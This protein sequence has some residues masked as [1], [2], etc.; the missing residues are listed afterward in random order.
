MSTTEAGID[1]AAQPQDLGNIDMKIEVVTIPVSDV[2]R[3]KAFYQGLGWR[4]DADFSPGGPL[5]VVQMTPLHSGASI[6]FS[7][8]L[9]TAFGVPEM[10]PGSQHRLELIVSD[11]E[12]A[13]EDLISRGADVGELFHLGAAGPEPGPDPQRASYGTYAVFSDPDG[14]TWLLQEV[15][16]R[17]PGR[18]WDS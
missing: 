7:N 6:S 14:N 18:L 9:N 13:R 12:A 3:A 10:E 16:E 15:N 8:G 5:R 11:I 4:V 1:A 17:R 2:E